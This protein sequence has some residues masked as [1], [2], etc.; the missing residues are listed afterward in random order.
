MITSALLAIATISILLLVLLYFEYSAPVQ[1]ND[2][3]EDDYKE[4]LNQYNCDHRGQR[5]IVYVLLAS[6][7]GFYVYNKRNQNNISLI[8]KIGGDEKDFYKKDINDEEKHH[9]AI[10]K[11]DE[12]QITQEQENQEQENQE[13]EKDDNNE[14]MAL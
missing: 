12:L 3:N 11:V 6:S 2:E 10:Q 9:K 4:R 13:Q 7:L 14:T 1:A 5:N 8:E